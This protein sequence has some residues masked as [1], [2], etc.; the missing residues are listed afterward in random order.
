M[1]EL[2]SGGLKAILGFLPD[3][4]V[5]GMLDDLA[6]NTQITQMLGM[7][8]WFIPFYLFVP[9]L[10]AWLGCIALYYVY[11]VVLRWLHAIE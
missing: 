2:I 1:G 10:T 3:S 4:P 6:A 5:A 11:Q 9:I 7:L 8:N